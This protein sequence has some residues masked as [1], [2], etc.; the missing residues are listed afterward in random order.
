VAFRRAIH[1]RLSVLL[2]SSIG[3]SGINRRCLARLD[4]IA[5][6]TRPRRIVGQAIR[7]LHRALVCESRGC[8]CLGCAIERL[9]GVSLS[10]LSEPR[11]DPKASPIWHVGSR[12]GGATT[13]GASP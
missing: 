2:A 13:A 9:G 10:D 1:N 3:F 7:R 4:G 6:L 12:A 11:T 8:V 5:A